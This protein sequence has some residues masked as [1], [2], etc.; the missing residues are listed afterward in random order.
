MRLIILA[1]I[2]FS[3]NQT[4]NPDKLEQNEEAEIHMAFQNSRP[5]MR[6][7][8]PVQ[9]TSRMKVSD[10]Q[11]LNDTITSWYENVGAEEAGLDYNAF[12]YGIIG[13]LSLKQDGKLSE[14]NLVSIIDYTQSSCEKR[15]Y[16]IDLDDEKI[17]FNTYVS[18]GQGTGGNFAE[19]F[20]N[21]PGSHQSSI[22]FYVTGDTYVGSKGYSLRLHGEE[23]GINDKAFERAIVMHQADYVSE[24]WIKKYGRIGRSYGCPALPVGLSKKVI[25]TIKD[26]TAIFAYFDDKEYLKASRHLNVEDL[27][28]RLNQS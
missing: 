10:I 2:F 8:F 22:G 4:P 23:R 20:S 25:E 14:R 28:E 7:K 24:N 18:H 12:R 19:K 5:V 15:F 3:C 9:D 1:L 11:A 17:I 13:F 6:E 16:T 26:K 27:L 21:I